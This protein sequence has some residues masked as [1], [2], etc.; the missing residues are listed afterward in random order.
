MTDSLVFGL[1]VKSNYIQ[2]W[3]LTNLALTC[4]LI[5]I[6]MD[7][8]ETNAC[9]FTFFLKVENSYMHK[10]QSLNQLILFLQLSVSSLTVTSYWDKEQ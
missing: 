1:L 6:I 4:F 7:T 10:P 9:L 5:G 8:V 3:L 2:L